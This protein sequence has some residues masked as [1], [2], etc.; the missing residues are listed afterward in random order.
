MNLIGCHS[1]RKAKF[2]GK[3]TTSDAIR[4]MKLKLC[5]NIHSISL[6]K[7]YVLLTLLMCFRCYGNLKFPLTCNGKNENWHSLLSRCIYFGKKFQKC[8]LSSSL[9]NVSIELPHDKTNNVVVRP[10]KTQLSHP[11]SL[12]RVFAVRMKKA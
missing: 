3:I 2:A 5:R 11:P 6:Y 4:G 12:I 1:N 9:P 8:S 10:A 7:H